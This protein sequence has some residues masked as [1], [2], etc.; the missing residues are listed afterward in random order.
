VPRSPKPTPKP[1]PKAKPA[2]GDV[3]RAAKLSRVPG[4][5][6]A[7]AAARFAVPAPAVARARK[8]AKALSLAELALAALTDNGARGSGT[9]TAA[10]LA[11]IASFIDYVNHDGC[12]ADEVRALLATCARDG[13]LALRGDA[14]SL[15]AAWP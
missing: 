9:L 11:Q 3:A 7:E 4:V 1:T 2:P 14:W 13:T 5:T 12:T 10:A 6:I 8:A 15:G